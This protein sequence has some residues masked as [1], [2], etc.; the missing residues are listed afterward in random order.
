MT[1]QQRAYRPIDYFN[2]ETMNRMN[3]HYRY[4]TIFVDQDHNVM[5]DDHDWFA[6]VDQNIQV[7]YPVF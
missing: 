1:Y 5:T 4:K 6:A 2:S 3:L 7:L